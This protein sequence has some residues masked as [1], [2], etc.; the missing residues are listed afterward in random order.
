MRMDGQL[1]SPAALPPGKTW[2][3]L[4]RRLGGSH[5]QSGQVQKI[6]PPPG[7]EPLIVQSIASRY[8]DY[9]ALAHVKI[10]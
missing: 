8:I 4:Y 7:F 3:P 5:C 10:I 1:H 6:M 2:Y 9:A